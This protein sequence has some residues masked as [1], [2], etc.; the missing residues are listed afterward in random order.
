MCIK[1]CSQQPTIKSW[2]TE[3]HAW[4]VIQAAAHPCLLSLVNDALAAGEQL[5]K[6][7][8][9]RRSQRK[10][11]SM[12]LSLNQVVP[13]C[14][15]VYSG[16]LIK[17]E[18]R[19]EAQKSEHLHPGKCTQKFSLAKGRAE[20][21][22]NGQSQRNAPLPLIT[23]LN[24]LKYF[25]LVKSTDRYQHHSRVSTALLQEGNS[26]SFTALSG[27]ICSALSIK[28]Q[29]QLAIRGHSAAENT[30]AK[31]AL[32][33]LLFITILNKKVHFCLQRKKGV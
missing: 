21:Q 19:M 10:R 2:D 3:L 28:R 5:K 15:V 27:K 1:T 30:I 33:F 26:F 31:N 20:G 24:K 16:K 8:K 18:R 4:P 13:S 32:L 11:T 6:A 23:P 12:Q 7:K 9:N 17:P 14:M 29:Q 25:P 22:C